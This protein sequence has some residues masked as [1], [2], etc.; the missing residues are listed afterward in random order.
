LRH[1][2]AGDLLD[3]RGLEAGPLQQRGLRGAEDLGGVRT[4]STITAVPTR[5]TLSIERVRLL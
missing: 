4:A 5:T 2:A 1:A 3:G